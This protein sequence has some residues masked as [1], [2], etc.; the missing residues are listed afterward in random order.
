ML[1]CK[2]VISIFSIHK[3]DIP[4][5]Q[6]AVI[7]QRSEEFVTPE[8]HFPSKFRRSL[9]ELKFPDAVL[10]GPARIKKLPAAK[11]PG[12]TLHEKLI[13]AELQ[14]QIQFPVPQTTPSPFLRHGIGQ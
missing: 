7:L 10:N 14:G 2:D 1:C 5:L 8:H 11:L 13:A 9:F 12:I 3:D 6:D 4:E